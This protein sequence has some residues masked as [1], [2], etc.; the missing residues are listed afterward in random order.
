[1]AAEGKLG[2]LDGLVLR[3]VLRLGLV[4]FGDDLVGCLESQVLLG[5]EQ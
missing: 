3:R 5:E 2:S 1:V 4:L